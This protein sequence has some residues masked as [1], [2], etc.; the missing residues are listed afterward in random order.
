MTDA[1]FLR[2]QSPQ[3]RPLKGIHT[4]LEVEEATLIAVPDAVHRGWEPATPEKPPDPKPSL[5]LSRIPSG[6]SQTIAMCS[7]HRRPATSRAGTNF[8]SAISGCWFHRQV[9]G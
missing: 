9:S 7:P 8:C 2:Y 1:D 3:S 4:A 5:P 6:V